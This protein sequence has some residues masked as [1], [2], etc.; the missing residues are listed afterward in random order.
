MCSMGNAAGLK[1][2]QVL[3]E[4]RAGARDR[5]ARRRAGGRVPGAARARATGVARAHDFVRSLSPR[6]D[7]DRSLERGHRARAAAI[8]DGRCSRRS[9]P[10]SEMLA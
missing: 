2:L 4:R 5:A 3:D 10:R 1:A 6:L 8:R 9:R 7:E